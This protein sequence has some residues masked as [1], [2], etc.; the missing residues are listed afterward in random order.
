MRLL[1]IEGADVAFNDTVDLDEY[2]QLNVER[3]GTNQ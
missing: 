2:I 3:Y 1:C